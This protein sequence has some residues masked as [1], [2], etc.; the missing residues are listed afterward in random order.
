MS[1]ANPRPSIITAIA[2]Y[3]SRPVTPRA[4]A[5]QTVEF[6]ELVF[7][8]REMK[9]RL[10]RPVYKS[11]RKTIELG[12][13]L[14]PDI[15]NVVAAAMKDWAIERGAT[16]FTHVFYPLTGLSAEKHDNFLS[17]DGSGGVI[18]EFSGAML[19]QGEPDASSFPSGGLRS[20]F[21][22]RGYTAWDVTSPAYIMENALGS[23]LCIPTAF[24]S[25]TG[26]TLDKKTPILRSEQALN[27]QATRLLALFG[28]HSKLPI[29]SYAGLEQ[30]F[31]LVDRMFVLNRQDLHVAGRTLF[32][33]LSAKGQE[34]G[35]QYF[36]VM[37]GRV[38]ACLLEAER[39]LHR[40]GV[41]IKTQ[42][43]EAAP[44]QY[45]VA[46][47]YEPGNLATDHNQLIM[48]VLRSAARRHRLTC[49]L[50]DKPFTGCN[51]S[52][53]HINYS[54]GNAELGT[55]FDPG[56]TPHENAKFLVFLAAAIRAVH[57]HGGL[58]RAT[59]ASASNDQRLGGHEAPPAIMS[60]FLGEQL[61]DVLEQFR[62]GQ[63]KGSRKKRLMNVGVDSLPI[64]PADPGD[65]NRTSPFAFTG[66]RFEFR[67]LG[68]GMSAADS[69][70]VLNTIMAES[71]EYA[72]DRLEQ[73]MDGN[74]SRLNMAVQTFI[75][76]IVEAHSAVIFN[77]DGYSE[78]WQKEA[79]K[80]GLPA[81]R[82]T[83]EAIGELIKESSMNLFSKY[84]V[85]NKVELKARHDIYLDHY[86]KSLRTE[87]NLCVRMARTII[88]PAGLRYQE[89]LARTAA[90]LQQTGRVP[91][92]L[93]LDEVCTLLARLLGAT[94]TLEKELG[95]ILP[96][97][98][99]TA[100]HFADVILPQMSTIRSQSDRLECL[101]PAD[102][103]PL[104]T[105]QEMLFIK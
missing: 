63:I 21:E 49:L 7:N 39:Q 2:E 101:I 36:G 64:L 94:N 11:L 91:D 67:A 19:S 82:N 97:A 73:L 89:E 48:T 18:T 105:Y 60:V 79:V 50:H 22:A 4:S 47:M 66:N 98:Q 38:Q 76:E 9:E 104:P 16:H 13:Q 83:P 95:K 42:H 59:V 62:S 23:T 37:P 55:L 3:Q 24:V 100:A 20:T 85:L 29:I 70:S 28:V 35:D 77:G 93:V 75:Q 33:A 31:F 53:K 56:E 102:L 87:A 44:S 54:I 92:T 1:T 80:R 41:P 61:T 30:E 58:L 99:K 46:P 6:G 45:E 78:S 40:L 26:V 12:E 51:G 5:N 81:L 68:A 103:W 71:L 88:F 74:A 43:N 10:P 69:I 96:N 14:E 90:A 25:W 84:S 32:G 27:K 72:A 52:G 34:F 8:D 57:L 86:S 15:A 17:Y 65:R